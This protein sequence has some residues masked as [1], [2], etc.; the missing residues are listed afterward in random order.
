MFFVEVAQNAYSLKAYQGYFFKWPNL[1]NCLIIMSS[2]K[3]NVYY[4]HCISHDLIE[5]AHFCPV[6][7]HWI[8]PLQRR[9]EDTR[10]W[11]SSAQNLHQGIQGEM[12]PLAPNLP[13]CLSIAMS[14]RTKAIKC[15]EVH[16]FQSFGHICT[17]SLKAVIFDRLEFGTVLRSKINLPFGSPSHSLQ[18]HTTE[19]A[20]W[21]AQEDSYACFPAHEYSVSVSVSPTH[22]QWGKTEKLCPLIMT[23]RKCWMQMLWLA[24]DLGVVWFSS[25]ASTRWCW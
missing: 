12:L 7:L 1:K 21:H 13:T 6:L 19:D 22:A 3:P 24:C 9:T 8:L 18:L 20:G 5:M 15:W 2:Y 17:K 4:Y 16:D 25:E 14:A 11:P 23:E 10:L